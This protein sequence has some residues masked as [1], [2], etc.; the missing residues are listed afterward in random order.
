MKIGVEIE[1]KFLPDTEALPKLVGG[2]TMIQA[3]LGQDPTVR[4]RVS[5]ERS[6][7]TIKGSGLTARQ[8][9]ELEIPEEAAR[10]MVELRP[11]D[12]R[13]LE[14]TRY[15]LD[16]EGHIWEVDIFHSRLEGLAL[17]E[18]E[19][20]SEDEE[21]ALP[22]WAGKEVTND[23]RYQNINLAYHGAPDED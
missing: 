15:R 12:S 13:I 16:F 5:S 17:A 23:S 18:V 2:E 1:R 8:E 4:V 19:L 7:L 22:P 11:L 21:V 14:K 10:A 6:T 9:I 20:Q 3:Y